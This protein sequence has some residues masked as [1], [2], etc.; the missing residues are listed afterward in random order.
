M[1]KVSQNIIEL[2]EEFQEKDKKKSLK[3]KEELE[4]LN[5]E[6]KKLN[7]IRETLNAMYKDSIQLQE[8]GDLTEYG[9]KELSLTKFLL[10]IVK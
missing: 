4:K 8:K 3:Q 10:K 2:V 7:H 9:K 5:L 1:I 6:V